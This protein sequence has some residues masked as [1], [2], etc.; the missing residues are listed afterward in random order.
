[1][2]KNTSQQ[3]PLLVE[4]CYRLAQADFGKGVLYPLNSNRK[5]DTYES[6]SELTGKK[7]V[8]LVMRRYGQRVLGVTYEIEF[9]EPLRV[10]LWYTYGSKELAEQS[11]LLEAEEIAYGTR[12]YLLCNCGKRCTVLY[13]RPDEPGRFGCRKCLNLQYELQTINP[14]SFAGRLLYL[15]SRHYKLRVMQTNVSRVTHGFRYTR[16][17]ASA[18]RLSKVLSQH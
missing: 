4:E 1:M 14:T 13:M 10:D 11:I 7:G 12:Y 9:D 2:E 16:K 18:L 5:Y 6:P 15:F 17:A 8:A 3:Q